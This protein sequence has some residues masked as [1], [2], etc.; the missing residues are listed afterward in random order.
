MCVFVETNRIFMSLQ[1]HIH[2][3]ILSALL[4]LNWLFSALKLLSVYIYIY[5]YI[6]KEGYKSDQGYYFYTIYFLIGLNK[7]RL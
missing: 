1:A 2:R 5:I 3:C 6:Y 7:V 4:T